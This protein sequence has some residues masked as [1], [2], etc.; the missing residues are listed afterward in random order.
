MEQKENFLIVISKSRI[1]YNVLLFAVLLSLILF[2]M[3]IK[4]SNKLKRDLLYNIT[5]GNP[6]EIADQCRVC[7]ML[8]DC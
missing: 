1:T 4:E 6:K 3:Q 5:N 7:C 8:G 2:T